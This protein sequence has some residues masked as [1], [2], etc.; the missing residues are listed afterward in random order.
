MTAPLISTVDLKQH[1]GIR[2]GLLGRAHAVVR[3]VDGVSLDIARGEV[4]GLV[5]ESGSGKSTLG[6]AFMALQPP[7]SGAMRF[8]GVDLAGL[9]AP[10]L[11]A[12][13][14]RMQMV[15]QDPFSSL[16][17]RMTIAQTLTMPLRFN[18]PELSAAE[19]MKRAGDGLERV[20]L[21]RAYL[22]RY[23]H[24]FSGGQR[25]R[26]GV[27]RALMV[28][29]DF[30]MADEAVSALDVSVQA[31]VLNLLTRIRKEMN[32]TMLFVTH[33][34]AVV[35]HVSDRVAVMYLGRVVEIAPT[36]TLF[37]RPRHPYT[38]A[39]LSAAPE[40]TPGRAANRIVLKGDIPSPVNPPSGCA[41][42][43]RCRYA[44]PACAEARPVLRDRGAG[45]TAACIRDDLDLAPAPGVTP[46]EPAE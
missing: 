9:S 25:Q 46:M 31:Q 27:A 41:F 16:N 34:L 4:L 17:P 19:K 2:Q 10:E 5:G 36:R 37:A 15:F 30:L 7:T 28:E 32:L 20:G 33:D 35:G 38:E 42:R 8:D 14:R 6:R 44:L 39:L 13:R 11:K 21:P 43:T 22:T 40:P 23:P 1:F 45:T 26:I 24:E 29:P 12:Y 3:A 18:A